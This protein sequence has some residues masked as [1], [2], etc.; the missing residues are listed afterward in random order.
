MAA[1][2]I[3]ITIDVDTALR[4]TDMEN[5]YA[6]LGGTLAAYFDEDAMSKGDSDDLWQI[7]I[8]LLDAAIAA[9]DRYIQQQ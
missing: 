6:E 9:S 1:D 3:T 7:S 5:R 4:L 8:D 2:Q